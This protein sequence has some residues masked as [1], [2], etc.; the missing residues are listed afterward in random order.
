MT[1]VVVVISEAISIWFAELSSNGG[2]FGVAISFINRV[3]R[4]QAHAAFLQAPCAYSTVGV[5][6]WRNAIHL[7]MNSLLWCGGTLLG[8]ATVT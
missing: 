3:P 2:H 7:A 8:M 6:D 1:K 5:V 4:F